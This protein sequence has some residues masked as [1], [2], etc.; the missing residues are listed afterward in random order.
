MS[1][2]ARE[3]VLPTP[4]VHR[5]RGRCFGFFAGWRIQRLLYQNHC[6]GVRRMPSSRSF[7]DLA[8]E[9]LR[10]GPAVGRRRIGAERREVVEDVEAV[11]AAHDG[12]DNGGA[13]GD[14]EE[15]AAMGDVRGAVQEEGS[16]RVC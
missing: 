9:S 15:R 4:S 7:H 12:D 11:F 1:S 13:G 6:S 16:R 10:L 2:R 14:G 8:R 3:R 5:P